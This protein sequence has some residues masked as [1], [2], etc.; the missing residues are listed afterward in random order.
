MSYT[1]NVSATTRKEPRTSCHLEF[2]SFGNLNG[3]ITESTWSGTIDQG[4]WYGLILQKCW[5][6]KNCQYLAL[7]L[8]CGHAQ[9]P[10]WCPVVLGSG[11]LSKFE[12]HHV[13]PCG[14]ANV[15]EVY[16]TL[17]AWSFLNRENPSALWDFMG[18]HMK[19]TR[20]SQQ[21]P[22]RKTRTCLIQHSFSAAFT[23]IRQGTSNFFWSSPIAGRYTRVPGVFLVKSWVCLVRSL[24]WNCEPVVL[25]G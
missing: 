1:Y 19:T 4:V 6:N 9:L 25:K 7:G 24:R 10:Y 15:P 21:Y 22:T 16:P 14:A 5:W 2:W 20:H 3:T 23:T 11:H 12:M 17:P 13:D 18:V 8:S